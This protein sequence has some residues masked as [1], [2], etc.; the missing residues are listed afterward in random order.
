VAEVINRALQTKPTDGS[1]QGTTRSLAAATGTSKRTAHRW[2]QTP[3]FYRL[4]HH[5]NGNKSS[6]DFGFYGLIG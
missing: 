2:L 5:S 4:N 1:T 6:R 3:G